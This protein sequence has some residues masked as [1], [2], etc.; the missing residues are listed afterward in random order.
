MG[1]AHFIR[2]MHMRSKTARSAW[3]VYIPCS[4]FEHHSI[5][6]MDADSYIACLLRHSSLCAVVNKT[7]LSDLLCFNLYNYLLQAQTME[8]AT[9]AYLE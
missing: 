8:Y 4:A 1:A 9:S 5:C 7:C 6:F 2:I 3:S